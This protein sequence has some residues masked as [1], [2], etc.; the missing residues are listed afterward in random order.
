MQGNGMSLL[1]FACWSANGYYFAKLLLNKGTDVNS[2]DKYAGFVL[3]IVFLARLSRYSFGVFS[4]LLINC[5]N[6]MPSLFII[7][8]LFGHLHHFLFLSFAVSLSTWACVA[9]MQ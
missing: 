7:A 6:S 2:E 1:H 9:F 3:S 5:P 8:S 4:P